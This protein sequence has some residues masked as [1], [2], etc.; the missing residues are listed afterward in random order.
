MEGLQCTPVMGGGVGLQ[1][2]LTW[3]Q[4]YN[5]RC[6]CEVTRCWGEGLGAEQS[7]RGGGGAG[8]A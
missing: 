4:G 3:S 5:L 7:D 8:V 6:R 1:A 2:Y